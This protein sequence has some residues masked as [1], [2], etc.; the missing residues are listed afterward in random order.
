MR[1]QGIQNLYE[2]IV[3]SNQTIYGVEVQKQLIH[4]RDK[5]LE[6]ELY[7]LR[8]LIREKELEALVSLCY[9]FHENVD[10]TNG[11]NAQIQDFL[12]KIKLENTPATSLIKKVGV[13]KRNPGM[14]S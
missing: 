13:L 11:T 14:F 7:S 5:F 10:L 6:S 3:K 1:V 4:L 9:Q 8:G 12:G 2:E